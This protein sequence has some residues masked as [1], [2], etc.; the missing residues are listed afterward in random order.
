MSAPVLTFIDY[1]KD[2]LLKTDASKEGLGVVLSQKQADGQYHLVTYG[3]WA[4]TAHEKN[5]HSTKLEFL[6]LK[7][8][9]MEHF[10]ENL[11][12]QPFL[13]RPENNPLTYI[14]T[15]P[16]LD[17]TGHQW[18][19]ALAKFDFQLE[20]QKGQDNTVADVL[21]QI[22]THLSPEAMQS[23]LD[24]IT[25]GAMQWAEGDD[26]AVVKADHNIEKEV[27]VANGQVLVEMH[28]TNW[29]T[30]QRKDPVLDAVLHW[31]EAKKKTDLRTLLREHASS[32]EGQMV[33]RNCQ[34]FTVSQD[35]LYLHSTPKGENEGLLLFVVLKAHWTGALNGC[36]QGA[37]HQ[38]HEHTVSLL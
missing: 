7:W 37:G 11:L 25:L 32:E 17:A 35:A 10:K 22:T 15:T 28:V 23:V 38:G 30:A 24:G 4:L 1:T 16:N 2:F 20:Y 33:W 31:L 5:Y 8:A 34:N 29:A 14:M 26:P 27:C 9:I 18:V 13:V 21:S 6:V 3:S 19:G 12:Y 36:Y